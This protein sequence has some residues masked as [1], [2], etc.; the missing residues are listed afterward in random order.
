MTAALIASLAVDL[1]IWLVVC[2]AFLSVY[3]GVYQLPTTAALPH[4]RVVL[5]LWT[6]VTAL[7]FAAQS[8]RSRQVSAWTSSLAVA[9]GLTTLLVYYALVI[10]GLGSWGRVI[11]AE[12]IRT[13]AAQLPALFGALGLSATAVVVAACMI[14]LC[15][16]VLARLYLRRFDWVALSRS[17]VSAGTLAVGFCAA[18]AIVGIETYLFAAAPWTKEREPL[19]LTMFPR[20]ASGVMQGHRID[21]VQAE[22]LDRQEDAA[23]AAYVLPSTA[24][25]RNVVLIVVD[26]LRPDHLSLFGYGRNTT[27]RLAAIAGSAA[28]AAR[29]TLRSVCA[30]SACGL[31]ALASSK[32]VHHFSY[33]PITLTEVL[34]RNGYNVHLVLGGDHTHF[35]G[36]REMYGKVDSY[37]DGSMA[38]HFY[39]NDDMLV[40]D[41]VASLPAWDGV[42]TMFQFHLMSTHVL[43]NRHD[44]YRVF[45]PAANYSVPSNRQK[46]N[47]RPSEIAVNYYDNGVLQAD[48]VIARLL[49]D[50]AKKQYLSNAVV[51][52]TADHGELLGEHDLYTHAKSAYDEVLRV[53]FIMLSFGYQPRQR[54]DDRLRGSQVDV[55]P[56]ILAELEMPKPITWDGMALQSAPPD[57]I[58]QFQEGG[59][60][61]LYDER[62]PGQ[63]WKYYMDVQTGAEVA[64]DVASNPAERP[65]PSA[66]TVA[67]ELKRE[68][69]ELV[70]PT[71]RGGLAD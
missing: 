23:R 59:Y 25:K 19:S 30:E 63:F 26:A 2:A 42:P 55:A 52:I 4:V 18:V 3:V 70:L 9:I 20:E 37:F 57:R 53:P 67:P 68:W 7:R 62:T 16:L 21:Q 35:Y 65:D 45:T 38:T 39:M 60:A 31:A 66:A 17:Q 43:G 29:L 15:A 49:D 8:F 54:L 11:S 24:E 22:R 6:A 71:V 10:V 58:I 50:L 44:E 12:L 69:R 32:Y 64:I 34:K 33:R 61:G 41:R 47:G 36:L 13:Y 5:T 51:V 14:F 1:C 40:L 28:V 48:A 46:T 27:P 56:T